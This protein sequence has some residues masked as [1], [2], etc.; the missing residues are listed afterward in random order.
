[1]VSLAQ[2]VRLALTGRT[3]S[4]GLYEIINII[5]KEETLVRITRAIE[6]AA[7]TS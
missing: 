7:A 1:M 2:P 4:P 5:G 6:F 3:A